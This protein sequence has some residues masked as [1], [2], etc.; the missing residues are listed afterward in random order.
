MSTGYDYDL[1]TCSRNVSTRSAEAQRW[2]DRGLVWCYAFAHEE[3]VRCFRRA[4]EH[5]PDCAMAWWG[6]G[7]AA[8]PYYNKPWEKFDPVEL[9]ATLSTVRTATRQA[10]DRIGNAKPVERALIEALARRYPSSEP[11]GD[12]G[13]WNGRLR[14]CDARGYTD[15]I[16]VT[17]TCA[18]CSPKRS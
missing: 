14:R 8:G 10:L 17:R 9:A 1:G 5:D 15:R 12:F 6:I 4:A 2:F 16:R 18:R 3:A 7:Y 13:R 11:A